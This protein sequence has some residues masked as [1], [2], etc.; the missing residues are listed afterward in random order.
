MTCAV[1][2][3]KVLMIME[4]VGSFGTELGMYACHFFICPTIVISF[5]FKSLSL[6]Q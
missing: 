2:Q 3:Q 1:E 4:V 5:K 6:T